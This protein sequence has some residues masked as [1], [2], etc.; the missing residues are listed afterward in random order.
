M[1][2]GS[3]D[4]ANSREN[5]PDQ[6][7]DFFD[8]MPAQLPRLDTGRRM[9]ARSM[10]LRPLEAAATLPSTR[11]LNDGLVAA[12]ICAVPTPR[13]NAA[14]LNEPSQAPGTK[15]GTYSTGHCRDCTGPTLQ[16]L[17]MYAVAA[18]CCH[19]SIRVD[20]SRLWSNVKCRSHERVLYSRTILDSGLVFANLIP[21]M[22][23]GLR[24]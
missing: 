13:P 19:E 11:R 17:R 4:M 7:C 8:S 10:H 5:T 20:C 9:A 15:F 16:Y 2:R 23:N 22:S 18:A 1:I 21:S 14:L 3:L 6:Y 24:S 12:L